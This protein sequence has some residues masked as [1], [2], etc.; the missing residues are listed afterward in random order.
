[1]PWERQFPDR[2]AVRL[3]GVAV[4]PHSASCLA[5]VSLTIR[6]WKL[7]YH[8]IIDTTRCVLAGYG[9]HKIRLTPGL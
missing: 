3:G 8:F 5:P 6:T 4:G 9:N 1:M 7:C 2:V